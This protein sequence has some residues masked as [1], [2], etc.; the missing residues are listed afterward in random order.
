MHSLTKF[1]QISKQVANAPKTL[2]ISYRKDY[3]S[4]S[5][6]FPSTLTTLNVNNVGL[7]SIDVRWFYLKAL[8]RLDISRNSVGHIRKSTTWQKFCTIGR[9]ENLEV[10]ILSGN[11]FNGFPVNSYIFIGIAF[12][13][14]N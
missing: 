6:S 9:L 1:E 13:Y 12:I 4:P 14:C 3:P 5:S 8:R 10:L 7:T 2:H 11:R